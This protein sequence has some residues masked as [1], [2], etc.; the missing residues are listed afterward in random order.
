MTIDSRIRDAIIEASSKHRQ[1]ANL[2]DKLIAWFDS[3]AAGNASLEDRDSVH[4]HLEL[5]FEATV[6]NV[7][8]DSAN[9]AR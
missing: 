9:G 5:L 6:T 7:V 8:E 1:G 3:L 2:S 4:R